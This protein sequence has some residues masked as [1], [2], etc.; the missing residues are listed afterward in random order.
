VAVIAALIAGASGVVLLIAR[1]RLDPGS[2]CT[3]HAPIPRPD[4]I[5]EAATGSW[6]WAPPT[7][8]SCTMPL[9]GGGTVTAGPDGSLTAVLIIA[10]GALVVALAALVTRA[11]AVR[12]R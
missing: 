3:F 9:T 11:V 4:A 6:S 1:V 10:I 7:G 12:R 2:W 8:L 5:P